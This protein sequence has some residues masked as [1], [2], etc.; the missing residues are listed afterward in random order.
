MGMALTKLARDYQTPYLAGAHTVP[1][2]SQGPGA[3]C[4]TESD[5]CCPARN[6]EPSWS[7]HPHQAPPGPRTVVGHGEIRGWAKHR[8]APIPPHHILTTTNTIT[9]RVVDPRTHPS[10]P[11][12]QPS[13]T[14]PR[15]RMKWNGSSSGS[16]GSKTVLDSNN[17]PCRDS[18]TNQRV[19][20]V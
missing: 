2:A 3:T 12:S 9:P 19:G 10:R 17:F 15:P 4:G 1:A 7:N 11:R 6:E 14:W 5:G 16:L 20:D 8:T 13:M 18:Q